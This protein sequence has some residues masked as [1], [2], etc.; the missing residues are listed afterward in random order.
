MA[1]VNMSFLTRYEGVSVR[2]DGTIVAAATLV[3][4]R[5]SKVTVGQL[6]IAV[7]DGKVVQPELSTDLTVD[8]AVVAAATTLAAQMQALVEK[9]ATEQ[10][11]FIRGQVAQQST[12]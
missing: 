9:I 7:K 6:R 4:S 1:T 10:P 2:L 3:D 11:I 5:D 8:P 12:R